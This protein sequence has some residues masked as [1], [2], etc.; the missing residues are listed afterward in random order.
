MMKFCPV[1]RVPWGLN[2]VSSS[3]RKNAIADFLASADHNSA[4]SSTRTV[5]LCSKIPRGAWWSPNCNVQRNTTCSAQKFP[6]G[7]CRT[8]RVGNFKSNFRQFSLLS[9]FFTT[10]PVMLCS[11]SKLK[12][13]PL[14]FKRDARRFLGKVVRGDGEIIGKEHSNYQ[15][16]LFTTQTTFADNMNYRWPFIET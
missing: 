13:G 16:C 14:T 11:V 12:R 15:V 4:Q 9:T 8:R 5:E 1:R 10:L 2:G 6:V 7:H 3:T